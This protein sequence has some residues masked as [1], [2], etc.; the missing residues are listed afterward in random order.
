MRVS[1]TWQEANLTVQTLP[2]VGGYTGAQALLQ[3]LYGVFGGEV[4]AC[5]TPSFAAVRSTSSVR[6]SAL[7]S[8]MPEVMMVISRI[9]DDARRDD[10]LWDLFGGG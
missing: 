5:F 9:L 8:L 4:A 1:S 3:V 2:G 6:C 7:T 10:L